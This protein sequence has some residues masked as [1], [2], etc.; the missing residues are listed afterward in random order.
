MEKAIST[1]WVQD[2]D[3]QVL[4]CVLSTGHV[5]YESSAKFLTDEIQKLAE[6]RRF[7]FNYASI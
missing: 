7:E 3:Y 6:E 1:E 4:R 2:G 5:L